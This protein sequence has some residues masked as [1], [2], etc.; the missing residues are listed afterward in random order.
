MHLESSKVTFVMHAKY[1]AHL[2]GTVPV[3]DSG[4][5]LLYSS[6]P[7]LDPGSYGFFPRGGSA[8]D[9]K[10]QRDFFKGF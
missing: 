5:V 6:G 7:Y 9:P 2:F 8:R 10:W 3:S 1:R 4:S